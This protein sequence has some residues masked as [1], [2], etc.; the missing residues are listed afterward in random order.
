[1]T[2]A[3]DEDADGCLARE[4]LSSRGQ[5][6]GF[7]AWARTL[8]RSRRPGRVVVRNAGN[9]V[10]IDADGLNAVAD[11]PRLLELARQERQGRGFT[12]HPGEFARLTG[13]STK[14]AAR[15]RWRRTLPP[16]MAWC[17]C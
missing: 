10:M 8:G 9:S 3:T 13:R 1:M 7:G 12:P 17:S 14:E 2:A 11:Q 16:S 4:R 5:R 15:S 6:G